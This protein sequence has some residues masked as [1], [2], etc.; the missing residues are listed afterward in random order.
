MKKRKSVL[1]LG[2]FIGLFIFSVTSGSMIN[3]TNTTNLALIQLVSD[4]SEQ[5]E[6]STYSGLSV[7]D[8]WTI[9]DSSSNYLS[10]K[11]TSITGG[12]DVYADYWYN[13]AYF[14]NIQICTAGSGYAFNDANVAMFVGMFGTYT[15]T[16]GGV[17]L[18]VCDA[19]NIIDT[20]SGIIVETPGAF[21]LDSWSIYTSPVPQDD[22]NLG[23][24]ASDSTPG[25]IV[26]F[27]AYHGSKLVYTGTYED[28][29]VKFWLE[30]DH[31]V[32]IELGSGDTWDQQNLVGELY[33]DDGVKV[34]DLVDGI[35]GGPLNN[36][37]N[38]DVDGSQYF[39]L[40]I[41][42]ELNSGLYS[43]LYYTA[44]IT[45]TGHT[46]F[47]LAGDAPEDVNPTSPGTYINC[48]SDTTPAPH[49]K[50]TPDVDRADLSISKDGNITVMISPYPSD[51]MRTK[52]WV[53]MN[54]P[55]I[56]EYNYSDY[57][58]QPIMVHGTANDDGE[59]EIKVSRYAGGVSPDNYYNVT[60]IGGKPYNCT[61]KKGTGIMLVIDASGSVNVTEATAA[62]ELII[63]SISPYTH[64]GLVIFRADATLKHDLAQP[65]KDNYKDELSVLLAD[66]HDSGLT[67]IYDG[68]MMGLEL[69]PL[70][71]FETQK[72]ILFT[73]GYPTTSNPG[74]DKFGSW[75]AGSQTDWESDP[76][77]P[78]AIAAER[79][80]PIAAVSIDFPINNEFFWA[81]GNASAN[82]TV[83]N[84]N[85]IWDLIDELQDIYRSTEDWDH[86]QGW[87]G[88]ISTGTC[89]L[90]TPGGLDVT[91]KQG[92]SLGLTMWWLDTGHIGCIVV[93]DQS[94]TTIP[95]ISPTSA[96]GERP[97]T[98]YFIVDSSITTIYI[99]GCIDT[100]TLS[101]SS[102]GDVDYDLDLN[103][104][105]GTDF[106]EWMSDP[107]PS[108][109][110]GA[111]PLGLIFLLSAEE[112]GPLVLV[113]V[114]IGIAAGVVVAIIIVKQKELF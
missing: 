3:T 40:K 72:L 46:D 63:E 67:N 28:D 82:N 96:Y 22:F 91:S 83:H 56:T 113:L 71:C 4:F 52:F 34:M 68:L 99:Y 87:E 54:G 10:F 104:K 66:I 62:C 17:S 59:V 51:N 109:G 95:F 29:H 114:L 88:T 105:N 26:G 89:K 79:G 49:Q 7:G 31:T 39:T 41:S 14:S 21:I 103:T 98:A 64:V 2:I 18:T 69:L 50:Y 61:D 100:C 108:G 45:V 33:N 55:G 92:Y 36:Y 19:G 8:E 85:D 76:E 11:V 111:S 25:D 112:P 38:T 6:T 15:D 35:W 47:Y 1:F 102:N 27:G 86:W 93:T 81:V 44:M 73:D 84:A 30:E 20:A 106:Q 75:G 42:G 80:V 23:K 90:I 16:Y 101:S 77:S 9:L 48:L 57:N 65:A 24:D 70:K 78:L 37:T 53:T 58:G 43:D 13:G 97:Y 110:G 32:S 60:I 5:L 74:K 94:N 107:Y 12:D